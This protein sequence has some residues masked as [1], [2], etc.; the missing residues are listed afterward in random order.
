M[1]FMKKENIPLLDDTSKALSIISCA[2]EVVIGNDKYLARID[3][4]ASKNSICKSIVKKYN[5]GPSLRLTTIKQSN[6]LKNRV[7]VKLK[8]QIADRTFKTYFNVSNRENMKYPILIGRNLLN[9][10]FMV[11]CRE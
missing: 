1:D 2:E 3:T 8:V 6:G 11:D 4:G 7:V 10:N 9:K 5:L